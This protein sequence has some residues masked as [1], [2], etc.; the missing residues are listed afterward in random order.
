MVIGVFCFILSQNVTFLFYYVLT[1]L[2]HN[3]SMVLLRVV[4][5]T[6]L[7]ANYSN[8]TWQ[9]LKLGSVTVELSELSSIILI[10]GLSAHELNQA[11][12]YIY[13]ILNL[14]YNY[15]FIL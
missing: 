13:T 11:Y 4:N 1:I 2:S 15:H 7:L 9:K 12:M 3:F 10:L 8:W 5:N 14:L 6:P